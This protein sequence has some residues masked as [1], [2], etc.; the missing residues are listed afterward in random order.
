MST[1]FDQP[2]TD[3]KIYFA[4]IGIPIRTYVSVPLKL[5]AGATAQA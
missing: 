1:T 5:T 2:I 3:D 4:A